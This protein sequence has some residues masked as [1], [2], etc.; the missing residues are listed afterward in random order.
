MNAIRLVRR[1]PFYDSADKHAYID[2]YV[3]SSQ[4]LIVYN[5]PFAGHEFS[6]IYE[7]FVVLYQGRFVW[8]PWWAFEPSRIERLP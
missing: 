2:G 7:R 1:A 6:S 3:E 8:L 5:V 4:L